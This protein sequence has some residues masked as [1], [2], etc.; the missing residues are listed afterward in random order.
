M[1][2]SLLSFL[3]SKISKY[4]QED[5]AS[6]SLC[7]IVNQEDAPFL[8]SVFTEILC[9]S[10]GIKDFEGISNYRTQVTGKEK[11]RPDIVG[12]DQRGKEAL[13][14]EVKFYA[15]LTQNQP[16]AY[17]KRLSETSGAGLV[18]LC[19]AN[20]VQ[21]LWHQLCA[22]AGVET[23]ED[24]R[25]SVDGIPMSI[26]SWEHVLEKLSIVSE[27]NHCIMQSDIQELTVFC[28]DM[29]NFKYGFQ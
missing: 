25:V 20:R 26:I 8:T 23:T 27:N 2:G 24:H 1:T 4:P 15:A 11:E 22:V 18:F 6:M 19:P 9:T 17:L 12:F 10:L 16:K 29:F 13:I 21:G 5:I 14:C 3:A 28:K 7:H